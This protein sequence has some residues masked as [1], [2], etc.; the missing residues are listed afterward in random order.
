MH[1]HFY[2]TPINR[3]RYQKLIEG[4]LQP[5]IGN[6]YKYEKNS[7]KMYD[8]LKENGNLNLAIK[9][10]MKLEKNFEG[11]FDFANQNPCTRVHHLVAELFGLEKLLKEED[12]IS[13]Y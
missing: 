13:E 1:F 5:K 11:Q 12:S 10:A 9:F 8:I 4:N 3:E 2:N 7:T 6:G